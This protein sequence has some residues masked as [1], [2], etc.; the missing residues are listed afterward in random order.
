MSDLLEIGT[1]VFHTGHKFG[2]IVAYNGK[3]VN[4][5]ITSKRGTK[6]LRSLL[7]EAPNI[8][9]PAMIDS[10]YSSDRFP[11]IVKYDPSKIYPDGYQDVYCDNDFKVIE[12]N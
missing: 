1:R 3:K 11:Y 6:T 4:P 7:D 8:V 12:D 2:T 9:I 5:Y 10:F